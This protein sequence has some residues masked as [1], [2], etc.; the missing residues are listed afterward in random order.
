MLGLRANALVVTPPA[1]AG[2]VNPYLIP[3]PSPNA[4]D[5][6]FNS[7]SPDLAAR[8][9][10]VIDAGS[11]VAMTRA[12]NVAPWG[13]GPAAN[14]YLSTLYQGTILIQAP[15][16]QQI[17]IIKTIALSPGDTYFAHVGSSFV[18]APGGNGRFCEVG[19]YGW[20]GTILDNANR[21]YSTYLNT[22][23]AT[24]Y[25]NYD[26]GRFTAGVPV[27]ISRVQLAS[28][29]VRAV[30]YDSGTTH[31]HMCLSTNGLQTVGYEATG[32]PAAATLSRFAIRNLFTYGLGATPLL[33]ID[34]IRKKSADAWLIP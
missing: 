21:V 27:V 13:A 32:C 18:F 7:G 3:P 17:D 16:G 34:F 15:N 2:G 4:F 10:T 9:Y 23:T 26:L 12:G 6:E 1:V 24:Q 5:D 25:V 33:Q 11:G 19:F 20:T 31:R 8:G 22:T 29:D 30:H 28:Y 14:T